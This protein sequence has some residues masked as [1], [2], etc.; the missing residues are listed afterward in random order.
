MRDGK[1]DAKAIF[2]EALD[3]KEGDELMRFLEKACGPDTALR[4]RVEELLRANRDAGAF[5]GGQQD[6]SQGEPIAALPRVARRSCRAG[7]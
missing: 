4:M 2:L 7:G 6:T 3:R 5:L 1:A